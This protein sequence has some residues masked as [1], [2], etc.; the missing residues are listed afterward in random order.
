MVRDFVRMAFGYCGIEL[1]FKGSGVDEKG[2]VLTCNNPDYQLPIG[3]EVV[4]V[5]PRYFRPTEVD[6]LLGDPT[7]AEQKLV[8]AC[9]EAGSRSSK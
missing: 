9:C 4:G 6:L 3:K 7:K 2:Y 5:D 8:I 1:E